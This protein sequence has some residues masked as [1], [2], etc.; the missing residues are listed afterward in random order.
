MELQVFNSQNT[1]YKLI[2]HAF[3]ITNLD[4]VSWTTF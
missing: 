3:K 2:L 1:E 4:N